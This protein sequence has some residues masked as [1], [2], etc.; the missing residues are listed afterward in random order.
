MNQPTEQ[1]KS[2]TSLVIG[3]VALLIVLAFAIFYLRGGDLGS[4]PGLSNKM[5]DVQTLEQQ[6][7]SDEI[8]AIEQDLAA[9]DLG[10]LDKE[11]DSID[12]E[13]SAPVAQ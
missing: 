9:T 3:I 10:N 4:L 2:K 1:H 6:G 12:Q 7:T 5:N 13:L 8:T 11:L